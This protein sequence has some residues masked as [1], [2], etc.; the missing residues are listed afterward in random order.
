MSWNKPMP[1]RPVV[2]V[3]GATGA[4]GSEMLKVLQ[5]RKFPCA[6]V[7]A[8]ASARSAGA[9]LPFAGGELTVPEM[10]PESFRGVDIVLGATGDD[11]AK[12]AYPAAVE[13]GAVVVDNSHAFR[14]DADVPL[15]IPE[16]NPQDVA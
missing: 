6:E 12:A 16:V 1:A 10:T 14:M 4:V 5:E 8:L 13:A 9:K 15:V 2:A 3:A 11:V 7:R